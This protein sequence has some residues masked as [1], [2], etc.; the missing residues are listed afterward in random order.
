MFT[1]FT[2]AYF[3]LTA[4]YQSGFETDIKTKSADSDNRSMHTSAKNIFGRLQRIQIF[5]I[6]HK[7]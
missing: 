1:F 4:A 6:P 5:Y 2:S 3:F 7:Y